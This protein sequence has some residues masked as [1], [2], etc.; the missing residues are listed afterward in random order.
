M[1][2]FSIYVI[3]NRYQLAK[4]V[5]DCLPDLS[6]EY[7]DGSNIESFSQLVNKCVEQCPTETI[8]M[9]SDKVILE[10]K[11][12]NK[13]LSL[14]NDGYGFV[15]LYRFALFGIK[16]ELF[17]I[18]GCMDERYI[19]GGYEDCDLLRRMNEA[20]ISYYEANEVPI[21]KMSSSWSS[22]LCLK[23]FRNKWKV[24][25]NLTIKRMLPE[26]EYDYDFGKSKKTI[27]LDW[28]YSILGEASGNFKNVEIV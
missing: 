27:F 23:H 2:D 24:I 1:N 15:G 19:G 8:I 3:S 7:F 25:D 18:I 13:L 17:R 9:C 20:N 5:I 12:I 11:Y 22:D 21:K 28:N 14:I 4:Q 16:K 26:E 6:V 10:K